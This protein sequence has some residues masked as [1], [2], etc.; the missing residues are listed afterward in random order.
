MDGS[1]SIDP[2]DTCHVW[3]ELSKTATVAL[4]L[5]SDAG[6]AVRGIAQRLYANVVGLPR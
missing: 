1:A 5:S 3:T 4:M 2:I 6:L